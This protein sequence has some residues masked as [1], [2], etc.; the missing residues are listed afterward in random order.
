MNMVKITVFCVLAAFCLL[1]WAPPEGASQ[2]Y[3]LKF[4]IQTWTLRNLS[5]DQAVDFAVKNKV[6]YLQLIG[7]H[8]NPLSPMAEIQQKKAV[9]ERNGLVCYTFGVNS[10]SMDKEAN[11][12]LFEFARTMGIK[13]I[14]VEPKN[15]NEWDNLEALVKEYDV[16]LAIHN[17]G[18]ESTY[19]NPE[20]VKKILQQ[21][22][23]RIG[24]CLDVGWVTAAGFDCAKVFKE[25]NGRV[26]DIH[27]KDKKVEMV[28]GKKVITDVALGTGNTN[29]AGLFKELKAE[30]WDG[31][32]A[33]ETDQNLKDPTE[34][35]LSAM[36]FV[37]EHQP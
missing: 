8:L 1:I 11:R 29:L 32:L 13:V 6:K 17:H 35:V 30:N 27:L 16:K 25:Y 23:N 26:F 37:E 3:R 2:N 34:Y 28:D 12:K 31:F 20:T 5:F 22:D 7:A 33:L 18:F 10:T 21:R 9:L 24:V 19:G 36:K 14:A 4:A 15:M